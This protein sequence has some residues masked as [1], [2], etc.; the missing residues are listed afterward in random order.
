MGVFIF[1]EPVLDINVLTQ[2]CSSLTQT[3]IE[4]MSALSSTGADWGEKII[5][6][7][8]EKWVLCI[9]ARHEDNLDGFLMTSLERI[10]GTPTVLIGLACL[11]KGDKEVFQA[12]RS[13]LLRKAFVSFPDEDVIITIRTSEYGPLNFLEGLDDCHPNVAKAPNG[14]QRAWGRRIAKRFEVGEFDDVLMQASS[15]FEY[16]FFDYPGDEASVKET[17]TLSKDF[18]KFNVAWGWALTEYLEASAN[19]VS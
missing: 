8:A 5:E 14:E 6:V 2:D 13:E 16:K 11:P 17:F 10:G 19:K 15:E 1:K 9:T 7:C 4:Q 3:D 12:I 18:N